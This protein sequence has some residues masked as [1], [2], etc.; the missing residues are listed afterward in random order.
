M[1]MDTFQKLRTINILSPSLEKEK[2][3]FLKR[4]GAMLQEGYSMKHALEFIDTFEKDPVKSWITS[5]QKGLLKGSSFHGEL[6]RIGFSDKVC[7]QIYFASQYG[8]Y[9]KSIS[10]CGEQ[11][12]EQDEMKRK[13]RSLLSYPLVLLFFL[14]TMLFMMRF[15]ILPNLATFLSANA[16]QTTIYS[17][18]FVS[19]IYY[20]PQ[21]IIGFVMF[22]VLMLSI[23][24]RKLAQLSPLARIDYFMKWP[25]IKVYLKD[26]WTHFL[27]LEWGQLLK[28][29]T[30][31]QEL[32]SIMSRK[33]ASPILQET[34]S[35]LIR[36]MSLG[37]SMKEAL[38]VLPFFHEEALV[39]ISHGEN[40][41]Q[42]STEMLVYASYCEGELTNRIEKMLG[43][44]QPLIF[45]FVALMIIAI[46]A[47]MMLPIFSLMEG[48][49]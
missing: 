34:G 47:S 25:G 39:V 37:K 17:N 10:Y 40:L 5:I 21:L 42:L 8:N 32:V 7:S 19:F 11:L 6:A 29:G 23:L 44:L 41:G 30:S 9:A 36:E 35:V 28:N 46:Y 13:L 16:T 12:L 43:K 20:S 27:F 45:V 1:L 4:V 22:V 2:G 33:E 26:Y 48:I 49:Q 14:L 15:L 38:T 3:L 24:K 18:V 31:F